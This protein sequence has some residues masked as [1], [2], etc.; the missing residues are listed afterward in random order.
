MDSGFL[1][2]LTLVYFS[3]GS[4]AG[5]LSPSLSWKAGLLVLAP[6]LLF[7]FPLNVLSY[8]LAG[9]SG[10]L[11]DLLFF[12][13][14]GEGIP[15]LPLLFASWLGGK[16]GAR[17]PIFQR[18]MRLGASFARS[19]IFLAV[20]LGLAVSISLFIDRVEY[21]Q[22]DI[23][24]PG[25]AVAI[26]THTP[27]TLDGRAYPVLS[28]DGLLWLAEN[29]QVDTEEGS[30]CYESDAAH[31]ETYG[32]L[33]TWAAARQACQ[34]LGWRLPTME[35]WISL[36][37]T[38][39]N[40][41][42]AYTDLLAGGQTGFNVELGGSYQPP[43]GKFANL[44][45]VG[46]YWSSTVDPQDSSQAWKVRFRGET[47]LVETEFFPKDWYFSCRCVKGP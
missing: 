33:Y 22:H 5:A 34:S 13:L 27:I 46:G 9:G 35:E 37:N 8:W 24:N 19:G 32:R 25:P 45:Q 17:F 14:P 10:S 47:H 43:T 44:G 30:V 12:I 3:A 20:L 23:E 40:Y 4:F 1:P 36:I 6:F 41:R 15:L 2:N 29:L 26:A 31:C 38:H 18:G 28:V 42:K 16:L 39:G 11:F 7:F 21:Q